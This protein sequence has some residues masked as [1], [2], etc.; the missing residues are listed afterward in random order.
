[1]SSKDDGFGE[2]SAGIK[3]LFALVSPIHLHLLDQNG[4]WSDFLKS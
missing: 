2:Y 1:M 3:I 4:F